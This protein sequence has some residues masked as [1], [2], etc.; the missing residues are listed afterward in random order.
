M[1]L[2][3]RPKFIENNRANSNEIYLREFE[4]LVNN[5]HH[6]ENKVD[7]QQLNLECLLIFLEPKITFQ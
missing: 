4:N 5:F 6:Q 3:T 1:T 7:I 2:G